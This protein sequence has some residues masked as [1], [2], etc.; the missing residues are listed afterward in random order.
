MSQFPEKEIVNCA[1]ISLKHM[2]L[3]CNNFAQEAG[4]NELFMIA[5]ELYEEIGNMQ[6]ETYQFMLDESWL[7]VSPQTASAI[8]K[9]ASNLRTLADS[10][11]LD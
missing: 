4:T 2:R 8:Q 7:T 3:L 6:R 9:S 11:E 10:I 5:N 1:L